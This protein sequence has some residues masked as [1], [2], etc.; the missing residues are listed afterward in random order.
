MTVVP[1]RM[2]RPEN[3]GHGKMEGNVN[4][5]VAWLLLV[6]LPFYRALSS[7]NEIVYELGPLPV[8]LLSHVNLL[9]TIHI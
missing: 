3:C 5:R 1:L 4:A 9:K 7:W 6:G 8:L 2:F